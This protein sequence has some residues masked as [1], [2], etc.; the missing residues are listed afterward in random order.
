MTPPRG[1]C[2]M[3]LGPYMTPPRGGCCLVALLSLLAS[4]LGV[5]NSSTT[6]NA[7][8]T[9]APSAGCAGFDCGNLGGTVFGL[10]N[11][12]GS[13]VVGVLLVLWGV[14]VGL[15]SCYCCRRYRPPPV[16]APRADTSATL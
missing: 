15:F 2:C 1:A 5:A 9:P 13:A 12:L 8:A 3:G 16:A 11:L 14:L 7:T 10:D 6:S 4:S